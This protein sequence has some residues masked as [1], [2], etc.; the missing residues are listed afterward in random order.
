MVFSFRHLGQ[1][2]L[3]FF[4]LST[5]TLWTCIRN[6]YREVRSVCRITLPIG[7][8]GDHLLQGSS[9]HATSIPWSLAV[10]LS[11]D[12]TF[13]TGRWQTLPKRTQEDAGSSHMGG[14]VRQK[15][16]IVN[17]EASCLTRRRNCCFLASVFL[18]CHP[19]L[20]SPSGSRG[21]TRANLQRKPQSTKSA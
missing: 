19:S 20:S 1:M 21:I 13:S 11:R 17:E 4:E 8:G 10:R 18:E 7:P 15:K 3:P 12:D 14:I 2:I 6:K 16:Q 5:F 9:T